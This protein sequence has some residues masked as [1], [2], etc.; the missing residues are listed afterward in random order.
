MSCASS[1]AGEEEALLTLTG[2]GLGSASLQLRLDRRLEVVL[3]LADFLQNPGL[4]DLTLEALD[5]AI[6]CLAIANGHLRQDKL[7]ARA[8]H[9][10]LISFP[11][12]REQ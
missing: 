10:A 6:N 3:A 1:D 11:L 9:A 5:R 7:L 8:A 4:L 2:A 12:T